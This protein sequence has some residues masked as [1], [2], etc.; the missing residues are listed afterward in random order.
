MVHYP[1][2]WPPILQVLA[3]ISIV[4]IVF[5]IL[6]PSFQ[7]VRDGNNY[8]PCPSRMQQIGL[9]FI[10]YTQ[11][12][13]E[14]YPQGINAVGTG[15]AGQIY[16]YTKSTGV[17]RC[18]DDTENGKFISYAENRN[19]VGQSLGDFA[20][21]AATVELYEFST[22]NCDPSQS[23]AVSATGLSAP[24]NSNR[25]N[26]NDGIPE[27]MHSLNFLAADGHVT[28]LRPWEVSGGSRAISPKTL[29][30]GEIVKTF[31]IK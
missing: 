22:L 19:L 14:K 9:A 2:G 7:K 11:D 5:A 30:Q 23:E 21:P 26:R 17:Y 28:F 25:H 1:R 24:Q 18:P 15:W 6:F 16:P 12:A 31:A 13:D 4:G 20:N 27:N 8:H 10:Q 29:P 3:V